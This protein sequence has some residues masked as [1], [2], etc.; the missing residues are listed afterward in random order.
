MLF[1][2]YTILWKNLIF[3]SFSLKQGRSDHF[4][5][6]FIHFNGKKSKLMYYIHKESHLVFLFIVIF[7]ELKR[8]LEK[9]RTLSKKPQ[10]RINNIQYMFW[11][12]FAWITALIWCDTKATSLGCTVVSRK[13]RC[14][15]LAASGSV[16]S[17]CFMTIY[18]FL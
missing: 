1:V 8:L 12:H 13:P 16:V 15:S 17:H 10:K 6:I 4:G 7:P 5:W 11:S 9:I 2:F 18:S 3:I 14:F